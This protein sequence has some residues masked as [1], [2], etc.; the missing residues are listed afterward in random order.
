MTV[1]VICHRATAVKKC[2]ELLLD[3]YD[4]RLNR[5]TKIIDGASLG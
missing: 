4:L 2:A 3:Y 5:A 1:V